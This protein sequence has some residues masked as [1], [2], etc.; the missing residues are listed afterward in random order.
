[1]AVYRNR[2][3]D[4]VERLILLRDYIHTNASPNHAVKASDMLTYLQSKGIC[5][6]IKTLYADLNMLGTCFRDVKIR[7]DGKEKGY[8]L[9]EPPLSSY[10]LRLIANSIQAAQFITQEE[11]NRLT[12]KLIGLADEYTKKL[13][14]RRTL[15]A[16]RTRTMND[17]LMI[18][19]DTIYAA[20]AQN[21]KISF[22]YFEYT[23]TSRGKAKR[24]HNLNGSK[25]IAANPY[26]VVWANDRFWL[27]AILKIPKDIWYKVGLEYDS[28]YGKYIDDNG[29]FLEDGDSIDF[30]H[31]DMDDTGSFVYEFERLDL[32]LMEQIKVLTENREG[33][34]IA[35][36]WIDSIM[37]NSPTKIIKLR[38]NNRYVSEVIDKFGSNIPISPDGDESFVVTVHEEPTPELYMW[39]QK[40]DPPI[41]IVYPENAEA[42]LKAYFLSL[43]KGDAPDGDFYGAIKSGFPYDDIR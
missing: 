4:I 38:V 5:I 43:A 2:S 8:V 20:I 19:L 33:R 26:T 32:G 15:V 23:L 36:R 30:Q 17:R 18:D 7:Y 11:A 40:F 42:D 35:Q 10:D 21:K 3:R 29:E 34:E 24:Y 28:E 16:N 37:T 22:K 1:M 14:D 9:D 12:D 6:E 39:M 41:E 27:Y 31:E 13:L 25:I